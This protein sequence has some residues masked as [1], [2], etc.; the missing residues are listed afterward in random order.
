MPHSS[1]PSLPWKP[2]TST[3][4]PNLHHLHYSP[5]SLFLRFTHNLPPSPILPTTHIDLHPQHSIIPT[6]CSLVVHSYNSNSMYYNKP[7]SLQLNP[8]FLTPEQAVTVFASLIT[9]SGSMVALSFF[10]RAITIPKFRYFMRLY[11]VPTTS[12]IEQGN[13]EKDHEVMRCMVSSFVEIGKVKDAVDIVIEMYN[14]GLS[15]N[16]HTLNYLAEYV[17]DEMSKR[18]VSTNSCSFGIMIGGHCREGSGIEEVERWL[19]LMY[20]K[21]YYLENVECTLVVDFFCKK[22]YVN[23]VFGLFERMNEKGFPPNVINYTA[24]VNGLARGGRIKQAFEVLEE[25]VSKGWKPNVY[26]H[27]ALIDGLCK[28]GWTEK[29]FRLFLKLVRSDTYKPNVHT[30][31]AMIN[32]YCKE[33]KLNRA[34]MLLTRMREQGLIPNTNTYTTLIDGHCKTGNL[35]RARILM[36]QMV[37]EGCIPNICTYNAIVDGLFKRRRVQEAYRLLQT[38]FEQGLSADRFTYTILISEC[39]RRCDTRQAIVVFSKMLKIGCHPDM[40]T[41]TTIIASFCKQGK[42]EDSEKLFKDAVNLGLVP[43]KQTYTSIIS[44][45]CRDNNADAALQ[46]FEKMS[47][48][49]CLADAVTYGAVISGL[50]KESKL[51][52]ARELYDSMIDK[53]C[54]PCEVTRLTLAYGYCKK[55]DSTT[56]MAILSR[57]E[58]KHWVRTGNTLIR[59]LSSEGK[60]DVTAQFFHKLLDKDPNA[61]RVTFLAFTTA[62]YDNNKYSVAADL[63]ERISEGIT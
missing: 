7:I 59:K 19:G 27:T 5:L 37:K 22:G 25:M 44:G 46:L 21:G 45:Y 10:Y 8:S 57:L 61:D 39:C 18:G 29:A 32:G 60:V 41:Y 34:E 20:E 26:T 28:K 35:V 24:F 16:V 47:E 2:C 54:S 51:K 1:L 53:G 43:T 40:H 11:I 48:H 31:T 50:C 23:K 12:L 17:F 15:G 38:G 62:C 33:D 52:K 56:A 63:S 49:G 58:K 4:F 9:T 55:D 36:D 6:V 42:M 14:Q 30:Y 3:F 13:V